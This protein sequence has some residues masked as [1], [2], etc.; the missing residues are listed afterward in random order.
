MAN[1]GN[2]FAILLTREGIIM[3][4]PLLN[5]SGNER[6]KPSDNF[7]I[8]SGGV[9]EYQGNIIDYDLHSLSWI[10]NG[11]PVRSLS[12]LSKALHLNKK[13]HDI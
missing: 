2:T 9:V 1:H 3:D 8:R 10:L 13:K 11:R 6:R 5:S 7:V 4:H 12:E